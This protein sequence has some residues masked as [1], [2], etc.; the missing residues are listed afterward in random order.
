MSENP[1]A[2]SKGG[3][4]APVRSAAGRR[5]AQLQEE[6]RARLQGAAY[7]QQLAGIAEH[8]MAIEEE[9]E[10][11]RFVYDQTQVMNARARIEALKARADINFKRLAKVLPDLRA[12]EVTASG[13]QDDLFG[14]L[15]GAVRAAHED[16]GGQVH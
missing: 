4:P 6:L 11:Y 1:D 7:I 9:L 12:M 13:G 8:F 14:A 16:T 2:P 10:K 15:V 3:N 5:R